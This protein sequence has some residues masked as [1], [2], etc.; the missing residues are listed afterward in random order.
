[1]FLNPSFALGS[2][3]DLLKKHADAWASLNQILC[4]WGPGSTIFKDSP[5]DSKAQPGREPLNYT[6]H[7]EV[8]IF[9]WIVI[10]MLLGNK[11]DLKKFWENW[12]VL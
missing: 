11:G 10:Q 6:N 5:G 12:S 1:M 9:P 2:P 4:R 3:G 8:L 7:D